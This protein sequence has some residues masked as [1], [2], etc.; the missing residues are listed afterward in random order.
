M[1]RV[2][3]PGEQS[4]LRGIV[5]DR[6]WSARSVIVVKDDVDVTI[7]ALLP[8]AQCVYPEGYFLR[9]KGDFSKGSRWQES[10]G[11]SWTFRE[12][13]W[14]WNRLLIFLRPKRFYDTNLAWDHA[15]E[16]FKCY[17]INFQLPYERS[18]LGFD[19]LD[20]DLDIVISPS[21]DWHW[22]DESDYLEG[23]KAGG[24]KQAWVDGIEQAKPEVLNLIE[25]RSYPLDGSWNDWRPDLNWNPAILPPTWNE[26]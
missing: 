1:N 8:G 24:I 22:K 6:V 14:Q 25:R 11:M 10:N 16:Q 9:K 17:Y 7:L 2:W 4:V 5:S 13:T 20:L 12:F 15:T 23:I 19:T 18:G 3:K 21:Y 26:Y